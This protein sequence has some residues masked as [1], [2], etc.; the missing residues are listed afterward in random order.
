[1]EWPRMTLAIG[2][3]YPGDC[4]PPTEGPVLDLGESHCHLILK[5]NGITEAE[6]HSFRNRRGF[7]IALH[8]ENECAFV[9]LRVEGLLDWTDAPFHIG[10]LPKATRPKAP[11]NGGGHPLQLSI[12]LVSGEDR[13]I[14]GLQNVELPLD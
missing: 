11:R 13:L 8:V 10:T 4:L 12:V 1:M 9:L 3:I 6:V 5:L 2:S 14:H 7:E